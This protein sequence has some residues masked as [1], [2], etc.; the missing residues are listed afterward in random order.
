MSTGDDL[1]L[2]MRRANG[3]YCLVVENITRGSSNTL[4]INHPSFLDKELDLF[5]GLFGANTQSDVCKTLTVS[6][7][8][9]T[10]WTTQHSTSG[11]NL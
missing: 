8:K 2:T 5:A 4:A 10:V 6:D 1:R 3:R 7:V 9:I 11:S